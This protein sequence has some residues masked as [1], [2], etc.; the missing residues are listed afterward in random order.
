ELQLICKTVSA[1]LELGIN[2]DIQNFLY[3]SRTSIVECIPDK[4]T[5]I[6]ATHIH[7][8]CEE[9]RRYHLH[10]ISD[11]RLQR[12]N[13]SEP[14]VKLTNVSYELFRFLGETES[15]SMA[16][17]FGGKNELYFAVHLK[18]YNGYVL[19]SYI[20]MNT[21]YDEYVSFI[22]LGNKGYIMLKDNYGVVIMHP[23]K[24]Q[25][26]VDAVTGRQKLY[27]NIDLS[28]T[29][30]GRMIEH[31]KQG[32]E[33]SEIYQSYW[34]P[35]KDKMQLIT[36]IT[37]YT[38]FHIGNTFFIISA[39]TDYKEISDSIGHN[40]LSIIIL[41]LLIFICVLLP[42]ILILYAMRRS[43]SIE[44]E[45]S[46][47]RQINETLQTL[48][49]NEQ[50]ISHQQRLQIIGTMTG[51][52]AHEFN[53]LLTP[54]MGYSAMMLSSMSVSDKNYEDIAEIYDAA[55]KARDIIQQISQLSRNNFDRVFKFCN[56]QELLNRAVKMANAIKSPNIELSLQVADSER[57]LFGNTT[58]LN[59]VLLN[60]IVNAFQ[61]IGI[62][63]QGFVRITC[64]EISRNELI[65]TVPEE[66][67][68]GLNEKYSEYAEIS[69]MDNGCGMSPEV[70]SQIFTP[71][72]STKTNNGG[73]GLG[74]FVVQNIIVSHS[75][76][77]YC[78]SIPHKYTQFHIILPSALPPTDK[79]EDEPLHERDSAYE[80]RHVHVLL[81]DDNPRILKVL[82]KGLVQNGNTV[83][84]VED[85]TQVK[86]LMLQE[87][88]DILITD[89][90]M[91]ELSGVDLAGIIR[92]TL[93][94][95]PIIV[96]TGLLNTSIIEA[97]QNHII[98]DYL[99]K[100]VTI[101]TLLT[102]IYELLSPQA[103]AL[104]L[105]KN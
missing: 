36:K 14:T 98:D 37:A 40:L 20:N 82:E 59:Q 77:I 2:R 60:I 101:H 5:E 68:P 66:L 4:Q 97:K 78:D 80:S 23:L 93:P 7:D 95:V 88:F 8:L 39:V 79:D 12:I 43:I 34:W 50:I 64:R 45:N 30:L 52:I 26:G 58:Q 21:L 75:G 41:A 35:D 69:I 9:Y 22:R 57:G 27:P 46:Y 76:V 72:F 104:N 24:E 33:G 29:S 105:N 54:I 42:T 94:D 99:V 73:T 48:H 63:K 1:N 67:Q 11:I 96:L 25:I 32:Y 84:T 49:N 56:V 83:R 90:S 65:Q 62:E 81:V 61:A 15:Y 18:E 19:S 85:S 31:Q 51:G 53:N 6:D 100:P 102:K 86:S 103:K 89:D 70:M 3:F 10:S 38:P 17:Y 74:L 91:K 71:F 87:H 92:R 13:E 28:M 55:S 16:L 44:K 47:L